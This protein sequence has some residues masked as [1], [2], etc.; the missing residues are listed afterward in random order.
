MDAVIPAGGTID[1][2]FQ[3][4]IN[5]PHRALAPI[6]AR[7]TPVMQIVVDAL[8][9]SGFVRRIIAVADPALRPQIQGIDIWIDAA[10]SGPENILA[11]LSHVETPLALVCTSD[12]PLIQAGSIGAFA[13][14]IS[15]NADI[16][17]GLVDADEFNRA[18]PDAPPSTFVTLR[19][20]APVT[21]SGLF[22]VR[23]KILLDNETLLRTAF[24]SRKSQWRSAQLLGPKLTWQFLTRT[25]TLPT[26][27]HR[28]E[29][30]LKCRAS[31]LE[32]CAPD[33]AFDIDAV[34][35][36]QYAKSR[37]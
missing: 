20:M 9:A 23:P 24:E 36:Y 37:K 11:G 4:A 28:A 7:E 30:I 1:T 18:Y 19:D 13:E 21:V 35:D 32:Q 15:E 12:L 17:L 27:V 26:V 31:V 14:R 16:V 22:A 2:T 29:T 33:L 34:E 6:G 10:P 8:R 25:L 3:N 5:S